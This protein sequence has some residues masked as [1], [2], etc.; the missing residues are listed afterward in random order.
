MS[1]PFFLP[2]EN[3]IPQIMSGGKHKSKGQMSAWGKRPG[4]R[5]F[6]GKC[7]SPV[8]AAAFHPYLY[9]SMTATYFFPNNSS[10]GQLCLAV[11]GQL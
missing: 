9:Y 6:G 7:P 4:E 2:G 8:D 11:I 3:V 5:M 10:P 1:H